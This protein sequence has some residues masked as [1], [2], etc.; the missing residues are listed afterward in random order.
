MQKA[1]T[2]PG[3]D[4]ADV[5]G[6]TIGFCFL[7]SVVCLMAVL[8]LTYFE[9]PGRLEARMLA[10]KGSALPAPRPGRAVVP[11]LMRVLHITTFLQGGAGRVITSLAR[12]QK[13]SGHDV[14]VVADAGGEPGYESYAEYIDALG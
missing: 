5:L 6:F 11:L 4:L 8:L 7:P 10:F 9:R 1:H 12:A 13:R 3:I 2:R 14:R